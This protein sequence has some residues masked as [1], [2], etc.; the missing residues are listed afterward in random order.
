LLYGSDAEY[1]L[2]A[3]LVAFTLRRAGARANTVLLHT[4]DVPKARLPLFRMFFDE[5]RLIEN[6]IQ[7]PRNSQLCSCSRDFGHPQF[8]KLHV[9]ELDFEKVLYLDSDLLVRRNIDALFTLDA[10]AAMDRIMAMPQHGSKLPNRVFYGRHRIRGIQGGVM[11]LAPDKDLFAA[12]RRDIEEPDALI[13]GE[14]QSSIG[15]E[16][17][18]LTWRY[19]HG[20]QEE[21]GDPS[22]WTH[23]GC[24]YNYEV[25][26]PSMYFAVGRERWLWMDYHQKAA[27][28]HFSAPFRKRAKMLLRSC[29]EDTQLPEVCSEESLIAFAHAEWDE[30]ANQLGQA[31]AAKGDDLESWL[32][33]C[34]A[35]RAAFSAVPSDIGGMGLVQLPEDCE[36]QGTHLTFEAFTANCQEGLIAY[37]PAFSPGPPW[38]ACFWAHK[39]IRTE[40]ATETGSWDGAERANEGNGGSA[41]CGMVDC[42]DAVN[43][44]RVDDDSANSRS[45]SGSIMDDVS[46]MENPQTGDCC[47]RGEDPGDPCGDACG[48]R[49]GK[50]AGSLQYKLSD[51]IECDCA[52][53]LATGSLKLHPNNERSPDH[54]GL[55][56]LGAWLRLQGDP[57]WS[58]GLLA[59]PPHQENCTAW[60]LMAT[61]RARVLNQP[62]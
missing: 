60:R 12:M 22:V 18:Y 53:K 11:L 30:A 49:L 56:E 40:E 21:Y 8:L 48:N 47:Q 45:K 29:A 35:H 62:S 3:L 61:F 55:E 51:D 32:R 36:V 10:P 43:S 14:Y 2:G 38:G 37:P 20:Q 27:V 57:Q 41:G 52:D 16:Q 50:Q 34:N 17:D 31:V 6:P 54:D 7:V 19:C 58:F 1:A 23:L 42:I 5:V 28:L 46:E 59:D 33:G 39:V 15:N 13:Q 25:H 9:L 4:A 26:A 24:Q 44:Q